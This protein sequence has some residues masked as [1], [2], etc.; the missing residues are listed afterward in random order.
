MCSNRNGSRLSALLD[1]FFF[2]HKLVERSLCRTGFVLLFVFLFLSLFVVCFFLFFHNLAN[3]S[4]S[5][6]GFLTNLSINHITGRFLFICLLFIFLFSFTNMSTDHT[7]GRVI[8]QT[9]LRDHVSGFFLISFISFFLKLF[10]LLFSPPVDRSHCW[11]GVL[12]SVSSGHDALWHST[13]MYG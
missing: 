2:F 7:A 4:H 3:R 9:C 6:T 11:T 8:S 13:S 12:K 1:G 5:W 10:F